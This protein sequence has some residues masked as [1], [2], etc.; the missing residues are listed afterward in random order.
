MILRAVELSDV[1]LLFEWEN[2]LELWE[3]GNT[4]RPFSRYA[5]E[6]YVINS[7]NDSLYSAKQ[8]RLMIDM[9]KE[10][11]TTT[12]GCVDLYDFEARDFKAAVGI[13]IAK[14]ERK[15][16]YAKKALLSLE[17][18][19]K[20]VYNL[21][22]LYAYVTEDNEDSKIL[23]EKSGF[24]QTATLK[25]WVCRDNKFKNVIVYQKTL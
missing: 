22:Q 14:S 8:M 9:E 16:G 19:I 18:M 7:Q 6:E 24:L 1:D 11:I 4:M 20:N 15:K 5:I 25:D 17:K 21:H 2:D 23:F 10:N 13:F 3:V 12:L